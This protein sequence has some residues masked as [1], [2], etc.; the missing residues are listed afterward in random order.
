MMSGMGETPATEDGNGELDYETA[1]ERLAE[2][3]AKL[4]AGGL[5]LDD[6]LALW[7]RGE[8]LAKLCERHLAGAERRV[9]A[10][11]ATVVDHDSEPS[12]QGMGEGA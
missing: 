1:R 4:E 10:A 3:V 8:E 9:E 12:A 11:L 2:V 6:S 7:E 5:P